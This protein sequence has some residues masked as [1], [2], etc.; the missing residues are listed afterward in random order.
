VEG[1][2]NTYLVFTSLFGSV[3]RVIRVDRSNGN[4]DLIDMPQFDEATSQ[5]AHVVSPDGDLV[6]EVTGSTRPSSLWIVAGKSL[7][8]EGVGGRVVVDAREIASFGSIAASTFSTVAANL[9][10][11]FYMKMLLIDPP[12]IEGTTAEPIQAILI[13]PKT[14]SPA[15][16]VPLVVIPHGGP[17]SCTIS[18]F[19]PGF[20]HM[21]TKYALVFPNYRGS[22]GFGQASADSLLTRIG[23]VDVEDVMTCT[24]YVMANFAAIA[25]DKIGIFGGSHGGFLTAH[26]T[27]QYPGFFKAG[28]MVVRILIYLTLFVSQHFILCSC[29]SKPCH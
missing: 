19:V 1:N 29:M 2:P 22:I 23:H 12:R 18:S 16:P 28:T 8:K 21:A 15:N 10:V 6:V 9:E 11:P 3:Q 5:V 4:I 14:A 13:L 26:C 27:S 24:K 7:K 20:A 17:H 25:C